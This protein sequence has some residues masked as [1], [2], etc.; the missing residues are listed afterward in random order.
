MTQPNYDSTVY[1]GGTGSS[2]ATGALL[3]NRALGD[4]HHQVSESHGQTG[5]ASGNRSFRDASEGSPQLQ[6]AQRVT[7]P[8]SNPDS[9][10]TQLSEAAGPVE[11]VVP[12]TVQRNP[13]ANSPYRQPQRR[14]SSVLSSSHSPIMD[15]GAD[16]P[17]SAVDVMRQLQA[18]V[19]GTSP[20]IRSGETGSEP[21]LVSPSAIFPGSA[22]FAQHLEAAGASADTLST[23]QPLSAMED[24]NRR[25]GINIGIHAE[26]AAQEVL[27]MGLEPPSATVTPADLTTSMEQIPDVVHDSRG[28]DQ[29]FFGGDIDD[30][31]IHTTLDVERGQFPL[32]L[33][34]SEQEDDDANGRHFTVTLPMAANTRAMYLDTITE[35]QATMIGFGNVFADSCS[36]DPDAT[37]VAKMDSIFE[38][39]LN[40][41]DLPAYDDSIPELGKHE[42]MKHA[43]NSNSKYS[44]VYEFLNGLWDINGRILILSQPGRVF[45]YLEALVS[46]MGC[47][48]TVL[49]QESSG[50][51]VTHGI[52][53]VLAVAGDDL[54]KV[55]GGVDVVIAFDHIARSVELP[56]TLGYES[57]AP[58]ILSLVATYS[59]EHIDQQLLDLEQD[60][61]ILERKNALNL[62]TATAVKYLKNPEGRHYPEPHQAAS[63]FSD[64]LR[65]PDNGLDWD[66]QPLPHDVFEIWLSS[67]ERSQQTQDL[68]RPDVGLNG[69]GGRK[70]ALVSVSKE[71]G[72]KHLLTGC[73][74]TM[75]TKALQ[76]GRG[77]CW[78]LGNRRERPRQH[79]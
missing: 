27:G 25:M 38:Q 21:A 7:L 69:F 39:L 52:S 33:A 30:A 31:A 4:I 34:S 43:T 63:I 60:M 19:F 37:L 16:P 26:N 58:I 51:P 35:N 13:P 72:E 49:G 70:R 74:R 29:P 55:Q 54:S 68:S 28:E 40:L 50:Q 73:C 79:G 62:A 67:Q 71:A 46:A 20:D 10:L 11:D 17:R 14:S 9:I 75:S 78:N 12:E 57:M 61:D 6:A 5:T 36:R 77:Y 53:V 59:L 42:M 15:N 76:S 56:S 22:T 1:S 48:F 45:D 24:L 47:P 2:G 66:P 23:G 8:G 3:S 64:F 41:C 32:A 18:E 44:F 65:S